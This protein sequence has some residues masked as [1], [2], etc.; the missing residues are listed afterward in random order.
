M[1]LNNKI[2]L[3]IFSFSVILILI[4]VFVVMPVFNDIKSNSEELAKREAD[5]VAIETKISNLEEFRLAYKELEETLSGI[6]NLFIDSE[7]PVEFINFLERTADDNS[8]EIEISSA[9]TQTVKGDI[10]PSVAFQAQI[11]GSFSD[12]LKFWKKVESSIY[13]VEVKNLNVGGSKEDTVKAFLSIK[14]FAK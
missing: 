5:L 8:L 10:W 14:V 12:F 9:V 4:I 13:L 1:T 7:V 3:S 11:T 6:N 2:K